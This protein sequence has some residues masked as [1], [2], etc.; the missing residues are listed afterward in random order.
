MA[1]DVDPP[2]P[3]TL[4]EAEARLELR[5]RASAGVFIV[6]SRGLLILLV[7]FA[8]TVVL[9]RLLT[10]HDFGVIA[11]GTTLLLVIAVVSDGGLGGAL[12]RRA[13]PP[14]EDELQAVMGIQFTV[15]FA[16]TALIALISLAFGE[17]GA[18]IAV[19][20]LSS[21]LV[22]LQFPGRIALER[23]LSYRPL[24]LVEVTQVLTNHLWAIAFV[25]AGFGIWGLATATIAMRAA[26]AIAMA[27]V[28]PVGW[29]RPS[30]RWSTVRPMLSF[31]RRF[32]AVNA[33]WLVRDQA[34][35]V[36]IA[37]IAN[38]ATLGLWSLARRLLEIPYLLFGSLLRVS[39]PTMAKLVSAQQDASAWIERSTRM[40]AVVGGTLLAGVAASAPGLIPGL[41]GDEWADASLA[42]PGACLGLAIGGSIRVSTQGFLFAVGDATVPLRATALEAV[43]WLGVALPLLPIIG[44]AAVGLGWLVSAF[45][46]S[47][48]LWRGT[49][50]QSN[51]CPIPPVL[52]PVLV[53]TLSG[54]AGWLVAYLG[55]ANL[56]SGIFGGLIAVLFMQL[57][58]LLFRRTLLFETYGFALR[59]VRAATSRSGTPV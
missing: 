11:I 30:L 20:A 54:T 43:V 8:G 57:S 29:V 28:S 26:A 47:V 2:R 52:A 46:E 53:G 6:A 33:T 19:M 5:D 18:V 17:A 27:R 32:Q 59:S 45:A 24:A 48:V 38:A 14:T 13:E 10:P 40:T 3:D 39:L 34:L 21:P 41:F 56:V 31:G 37:A 51:V 36:G 42:V 55:G 15:T 44:I 1:S 35:S 4:V 49:R 16:M 22:A 7:G 58:L 23:S 12:I 50:R 25:V 9:A